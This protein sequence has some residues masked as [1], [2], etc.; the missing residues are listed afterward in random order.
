MILL[1]KTTP[2]TYRLARALIRV[3][4]IGL[5]NL[6]AGRSVVPEL[7]QDEATAERLCA[8]SRRLLTDSRAYNEMQ[9]ELRQV[10]RALG[11]P[12]ASRRAAEVVLA[13][14]RA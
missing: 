7:I 6:V 12:G 3:K 13:E 2:V 9:A 1:Y 5:V 10:R 14:C 11:E 4:W 8:E